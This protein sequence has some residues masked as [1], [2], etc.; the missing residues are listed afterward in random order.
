MLP[1]SR[2]WEGSASASKAGMLSSTQ[3]DG[4]VHTVREE[5][6]IAEYTTAM[7]EKTAFMDPH[8]VR[9]SVLH[10][11]PTASPVTRRIPDSALV[12]CQCVRTL[13]LPRLSRARL[14][15]P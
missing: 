1:C 14:V 5:A 11:A 13:S 4:L 15:V 2:P 8:R 12:H 10:S 7:L 3:N 9:L 6:T